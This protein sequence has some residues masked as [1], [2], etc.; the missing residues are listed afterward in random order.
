MGGMISKHNELHI[1][2]RKMNDFCK[3]V[4]TQDVL[5]H[6]SFLQRLECESFVTKTQYIMI[7]VFLSSQSLLV[8]TLSLFII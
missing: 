7:G 2:I 1:A 8:Q 3:H 4:E 5:K 6:L